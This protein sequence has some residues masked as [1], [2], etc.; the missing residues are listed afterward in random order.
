MELIVGSAPPPGHRMKINALP[1]S[2]AIAALLGIAHYHFLV[3]CW[4]YIAQYSPLLGWL[5]E[6]G[7]RGTVLRAV[8]LPV[9]FLTSVLISLPAACLLRMLRPA[10]LWLYLLVAVVPVFI[11]FNLS[12]VGNE[13]LATYVLAFGWVNELFALPA[14]VWLLRFISRPTSARLMRVPTRGSPSAA[15]EVVMRHL[16]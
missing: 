4:G 6:V 12:L 2:V 10:V 1:L 11:W 15:T 14:A 9:D 16:G 13:L 5:V 3:W 7:I 8:L